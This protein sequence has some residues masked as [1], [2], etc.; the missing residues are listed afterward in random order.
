LSDPAWNSTIDSEIVLK[1]VTDLVQDGAECPRIH[2][3][4]IRKLDQ[5]KWIELPAKPPQRDP[6]SE[7]GRRKARAHVSERR[8]RRQWFGDAHSKKGGLI[9]IK[10]NPVATQQPISEL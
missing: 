2:E 3:T 4:M 6:A 9:A 7:R 1:V 5:R 8:R 10:R